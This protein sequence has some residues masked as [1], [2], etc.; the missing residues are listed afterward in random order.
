MT[1]KFNEPYPVHSKEQFAFSSG[2]TG[3]DFLIKISLQLNISQY[4]RGLTWIQ[5][6]DPGKASGLSSRSAMGPV[7]EGLHSR[8]GWLGIGGQRVVQYRD[9]QSRL[10]VESF[11]KVNL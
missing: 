11:A 6:Q 9:S 7:L 10:T 5:G 8:L 1:P 2:M 4:H 3:Q